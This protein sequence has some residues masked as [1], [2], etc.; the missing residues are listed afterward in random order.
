MQF[1]RKPNIDFIGK[2]RLFATLSATFVGISILLII[3]IGFRAGIDFT[4]GTEIA[5]QVEKHLETDKLR[6]LLSQAKLFP[7]E[8]KSFGEVNQFLLR[9]KETGENALLVENKL[10]ETLKDYNSTILKKDTIGPKIGAELR[11]QAL[12]AIL[13]SII[14]ILIYIG[15]RFEFTFGFGAIT[16]LVHDV[17]FTLG[18]IIICDRLGILNLEINQ[19]ILAALLTVMGYSVNDTVIVFDRI[20]EN[21]EKQKGIPFAKIANQSINETLSRTVITTLT[22]L[23]VLIVMIFFSGPVLQGFA[24]T[25]TVGIIIGTYSS[26]FIATP[27]VLWYMK[28]IRKLTVEEEIPAKQS[29]PAKA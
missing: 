13:L 21:R 22:V 18:V 11:F 14:A 20:R 10:I 12:I 27:F 28:N 16:A 25:M 15:I 29:A 19:G 1:F 4:G 3:F 6:S 9:F 17:I 7:D 24:F 23:I 8:I 2:R 26:I 5:I